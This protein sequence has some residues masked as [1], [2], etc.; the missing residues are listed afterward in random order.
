MIKEL[1]LEARAENAQAA[2]DFVEEQLEAADCPPKAMAHINIAVDELYINV[3]SYAYGEGEGPVTIRVETL[4][5]ERAVCVTFIDA[6]QPF[7]PLAAPE[8]DVTLPRSQRRIGGLGILMVKKM[9][10]EVSYE[11]ADGQNI[12][13]IRKNF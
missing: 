1:T 9:M 13:R 12:L 11:Y 8:P 4:P 2:A 10:D 5:E 7:D 6:G 3:A